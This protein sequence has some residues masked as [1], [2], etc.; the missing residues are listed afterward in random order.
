MAFMSHLLPRSLHFQAI[1]PQSDMSE[2]AVP[3]RRLQ[4]GLLYPLDM[5]LQSCA[6]DDESM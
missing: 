3:A 1:N 5:Y 2:S 6:S 4:L